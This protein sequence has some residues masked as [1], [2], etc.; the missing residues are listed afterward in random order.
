MASRLSSTV[1][2]WDRVIRHHSL[3]VNHLTHDFPG[4]ALSH[5]SCRSSRSCLFRC[6]SHPLLLKPSSCRGRSHS[7]GSVP[8]RSVPMGRGR[9]TPFGVK[10]RI[11]NVRTGKNPSSLDQP[12]KSSAI[13]CLTLQIKTK[14]KAG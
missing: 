10:M 2:L 9:A 8:R 12:F 14:Q 11:R 5:E 4:C 7:E 3:F 1:K 13:Q 6:L